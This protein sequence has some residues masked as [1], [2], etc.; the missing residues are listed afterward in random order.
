MPMPEG[1]VP[2][3]GMPE[4]WVCENTKGDRVVRVGCAGD[5][6]REMPPWTSYDSPQFSPEAIT[7]LESDRTLTG[8]CFVTFEHGAPVAPALVVAVA[9]GVA[10]PEAAP[11]FVRV[12]PA[13]EPAPEQQRD[14]I[15]DVRGC[16]RCG[17]EHDGLTFTKLRRPAVVNAKVVFTHWAAC[18]RNGEPI[19]YATFRTAADD[20]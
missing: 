15:V 17:A 7:Q 14:V 12:T 11:P 6:Q 3:T 5:P 20:D 9:D 19:L 13:L 10:D 16:A 8:D 2:T 1:F 18:P 4:G